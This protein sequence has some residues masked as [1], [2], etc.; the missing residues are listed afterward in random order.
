MSI[1]PLN[2]Q[3]LKTTYKLQYTLVT[4]DIQFEQVTSWVT[5]EC[6][7][8]VRRVLEEELSNAQGIPK[9]LKIAEAKF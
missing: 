1:I 3:A 9:L 5:I 4:C 2:P 7:T 6:I 8:C